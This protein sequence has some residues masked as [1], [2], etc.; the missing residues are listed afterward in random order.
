STDT[1]GA[2]FEGRRLGPYQL[3][4]RLGAGGMGVVFRA[5]DTRLDRTVAI[6]LLST[7]VVGHSLARERFEK[8]ARAIAALN[9]PN[10]CT[11]FDIGESPGIDPIGP[12]PI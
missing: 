12:E 8:E 4:S 11:L 1:T 9:H 10:I 3:V 6:K 2:D 7:Q 5:L